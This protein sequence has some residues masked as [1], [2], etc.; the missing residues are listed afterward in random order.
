M[1]ITTKVGDQGE[2]NFRGKM[3]KKSEPIFDC[4]GGLDEVQS[5]LGI[6]YEYADIDLF[7]NVLKHH[8]DLIYK[9]MGDLYLEKN[10]DSLDDEVKKMDVL[11]EEMVNRNEV[12]LNKFVLPIGSKFIVHLHHARTVT[13]RFER[14]IEGLKEKLGLPLVMIKYLNRLS[15]LLYAIAIDSEN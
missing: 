8:M 3:L 1:K 13:R 10:M 7:K 15:D 14:M 6:A 11:I 5:L 2:T 12:R 4:L 9:I